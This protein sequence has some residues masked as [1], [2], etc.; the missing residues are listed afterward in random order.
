VE[1]VAGNLPAHALGDIGRLVNVCFGQH[2]YELVAAVARDH[3]RVAHRRKQNSRDLHKNVRAY[4]V[5]VLVVDALEIVN[6][7]KERCDVRVVAAGAAYLA[8]KILP[9]VTRV[10]KLRQVVRLREPLCLSYSHGVGKGG[11]DGD[12]QS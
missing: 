9:Q 11:S 1:R 7:K 3:I 10:M 5:A 12:G 2:Y 4:K 6:V 8:H